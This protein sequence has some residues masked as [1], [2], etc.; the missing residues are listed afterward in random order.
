MDVKSQ[1]KRRLWISN[2]LSIQIL[3]VVSLGFTSPDREL[4]KPYLSAFSPTDYNGHSQIFEIEQDTSGLIYATDM[5]GIL[6]YDGSAWRRIYHPEG[7]PIITIG[8]DEKNRIFYGG[9][10]DFGYLIPDSLGEISFISLK[11]LLPDTT[12]RLNTIHSIDFSSEGIFFQ[13]TTNLL[14][15]NYSNNPSVDGKINSW[16][17]SRKDRIYHQ[18]EN[19][20]RMVFHRLGYGLVEMKNGELS[21]I[22]G[23]EQLSEIIVTDIVGL[24]NEIMLICTWEEGLF[25]FDGVSVLPFDSEI[26]DYSLI[27]GGSGCVVCGKDKFVLSTVFGGAVIFDKNGNI[28]RILDKSVGLPNNSVKNSC[29]T[30]NQNGLWI[31]L[32]YGLVRVEHESPLQYYDSS[33]G[34]EGLIRTL[35]RHENRLYIGTSHSVYILNENTSPGTLASFTP[36]PGIQPFTEALLSDKGLLVANHSGLFVVDCDNQVSDTLYTGRTSGL[37]KTENSQQKMLLDAYKHR[38]FLGTYRDGVH[39]FRYDFDIDGWIHEGRID[40][41]QNAV[42][43]VIEDNNWNLWMSAHPQLDNT[44]EKLSFDNLDSLNNALTVYRAEQGI[45]PNR[46]TG[47]FMFNAQLCLGTATGLVYYDEEEDKF[48]DHPEWRSYFGD[49]LSIFSPVVFHFRTMWFSDRTDVCKVEALP[50]GVRQS[51]P[52]YKMSRVMRRAFARNYQSLCPDRRGTRLWAA[53]N[54]GSIIRWDQPEQAATDVEFSTLVRRVSIG[55]DSIIFNGSL[56]DDWKMPIIANEF[57]SLRFQ[58][59][60]VQFEAPEENEFQFRLNGI[61]DR[62]STWSKE[63]YHDFTYLAGGSYT[64]EVRVSWFSGIWNFG[65]LFLVGT[66]SDNLKNMHTSSVGFSKA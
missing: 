52:P 65:L 32:D 40:N 2:I 57:N 66:L 10:N 42:V 14:K 63:T 53:T 17:L 12:Q 55:N 61:D 37:G 21:I 50:R 35:I 47:P 19:N 48:R 15:L 31:P 56:P 22:T 46:Q 29:L 9:S 43:S 26:N 8:I 51:S 58:Y 45:P 18:S 39:S 24:S 54:D 20:G 30:D 62:W 41:T 44:L 59:S 7:F 49:T 28:L 16:E 36:I 23:T 13:E 25:I 60:L 34:L 3:F 33:M 6:V 27:Q 11:H 1:N 64:F 38:I 5:A 4:G